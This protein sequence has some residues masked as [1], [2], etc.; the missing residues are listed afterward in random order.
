[1][2]PSSTALSKS[3]CTATPHIQRDNATIRPVRACV[4]ITLTCD[5]PKAIQAAELRLV[6]TLTPAPSPTAVGEACVLEVRWDLVYAVPKTADHRRSTAARWIAKSPKV[7]S[8]ICVV[9]SL[10]RAR[11]W[12]W[13]NGR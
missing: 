1:M 5:G 2:P 6:Q 9:S 3:A 4:C 11:C 8:W 10:S 13:R 12:T 7:D